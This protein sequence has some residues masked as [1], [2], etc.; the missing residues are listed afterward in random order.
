MIVLS[1]ANF[2]I[3]DL[4]KIHK[5]M[6]KI[7]AAIIGI[8]WA[9]SL[10]AQTADT[11]IQKASVGTTGRTGAVGFSIGNKGYLG[12]GNNGISYF[13]DFWEY[14]PSIN[15]W[16]QKANFAGTARTYAVGFVIGTKGYVGTGIDAMYNFKNDFW[17]Y[18]PTTNVWTQKASLDSPFFPNPGARAGAC[19]FTTGPY[20]ACVGTGYGYQG[21]YL[22]D[23]YMY[24][25]PANAWSSIASLPAPGR[26]HACAFSIGT[27]GLVGTGEDYYSAIFN[28]FWI[29][30]STSGYWY[31]T[32]SFPGTPRTRA[33]GFA[34]GDKGYV[35]GGTDFSGFNDMLWEYNGG[36]NSWVQRAMIAPGATT[37]HLA[38]GF[39]IGGYGYFG[40]GIHP[41]TNDFW[42]YNPCGTVP[43]T[44]TASGPVTFCLGGSVVLNANTGSGL[45]YQW[46][47]NGVNIAGATSSSYTASG[48]TAV[49]TVVVTAPCGSATSNSIVVTVF[50]TVPSAAISPS[51]TSAFCS[52]GSVLLT[53]VTNGSGYSYQWKK[54]GVIIS[55]AT[56][57]TYTATTAGAYTVV[58]T[59]VCGSAT[60]ATVTVVEN[61]IPA[62][63]ITPAGP[64]SVCTGGSVSLNASTGT[65][66]TWQWKK[67]GTNISEATNV[68]YAATTSGSYTV[69]VTNSCGSATSS[70]VAVTISSSA[71]PKPGSISGPSSFCTNQAGVVYSIAPVSSAT[72]YFWTVPTG[73]VVT[74]GQGTT[75]I[76]VTFG[77]KSGNVKVGAGNGC[78]FGAYQQKKVTKNCR[79]EGETTAA[80][81]EI[82]VYPN[83]S[84]GDFIFEFPNKINEEISIAIYDITGNIVFSGNTG[85]TKFTVPGSRLAPGIYSAVISDKE[86]KKVFRLIKTR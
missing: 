9:A 37:R 66:F 58:I 53:A 79:E 26:K 27:S 40:T 85:S 42:Q 69:A 47:A 51:G 24:I 6:K 73:A 41:I 1:A 28:D 11:W 5:P 7:Y 86:N 78:G 15:V 81:N 48:T 57:S 18:D 82:S 30:N 34:I 70:P 55:G 75:S 39:S 61:T 4:L 60:S 35:C 64:T 59:N 25:A 65:G 52:G 23:F 31:Q 16:T 14:D 83:P 36:Q 49:Y 33:A 80:D 45:T 38:V 21:Y 8:A 17:E 19:A 76:T 44:I 43:A 63:V 54:N 32:A 74:A 2:H 10:E 68:S 72:S 67:N 50:S 46:R 56:T 3:C 62:A 12:T 84:A 22:N 71:P 13:N 20:T 29:Y 77:N